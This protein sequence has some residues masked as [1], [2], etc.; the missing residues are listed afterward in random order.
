MPL[1]V[2]EWIERKDLRAN[3]ERLYLFGDNESRRGHG[4]Q[5]AACR[6]E[7]NAVGV[8]TKHFASRAS[9]A[10][11]SDAEFDRAKAIIDAD[12]APAFDHLRRGGEVVYPAAG[13]RTGLSEIAG[14]GA[15][16]VRLPAGTDRSAE[17]CR[18]CRP[19]VTTSNTEEGD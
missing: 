19:N 5:A 10:Y 9:N 11:W 15:E 4:G 6:G 17:D 7:P 1:I 16:R 13:L 18:G 8:A 3:P 2:Q 12:L 14:A